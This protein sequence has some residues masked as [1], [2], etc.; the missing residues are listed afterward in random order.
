MS[1]GLGCGLGYGLGSGKGGPGL[2]RGGLR[3]QPYGFIT[4]IILIL[5][6]SRLYIFEK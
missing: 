2:G 5:F 3:M 4:F 1:P 6:F